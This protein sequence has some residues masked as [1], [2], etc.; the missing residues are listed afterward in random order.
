MDILLPLSIAVGAIIAVLAFFL[1]RVFLRH[2][3][4][5]VDAEAMIRAATAP[6][7]SA[8][9]KNDPQITE[10]TAAHEAVVPHD[11]KPK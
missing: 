2:R 3:T 10:Q 1:T 4:P 9:K 6:V 11:M 8:S 7:A 5:T